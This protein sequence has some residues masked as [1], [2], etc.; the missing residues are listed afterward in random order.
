[1]FAFPIARVVLLGLLNHS[2]R[3][4]RFVTTESKT[5]ESELVQV[6]AI[7]DSDDKES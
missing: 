6:N 5:D 7:D 3:V 2:I 1:M 4:L